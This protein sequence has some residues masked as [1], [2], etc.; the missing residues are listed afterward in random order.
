MHSSHVPCPSCL[1][2][3]RQQ[4][5]SASSGWLHTNHGEH[6][7]APALDLDPSRGLATGQVGAVFSLGHYPLPTPAFHH[8]EQQRPGG[9]RGTQLHRAGG[10]NQSPQRISTFLAW[11]VK[12]PSPAGVKEVEHEIGHRVCPHDAG[13]GRRRLSPQDA[14]ET[15][16]L[17]AHHRAFAVQDRPLSSHCPGKTSQLGKPVGAVLTTPRVQPHCSIHHRN[18]THPVPLD[19]VKIRGVIEGAIPSNRLHGRD[20]CRSVTRLGCCPLTHLQVPPSAAAGP[21]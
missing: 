18:A 21:G 1:V 5:R 19:L 3:S 20:E 11:L 8:F 15:W 10:I 14:R 17:G 7:A 16:T 9:K 12:K 4:Q 6:P 2:G 13:I